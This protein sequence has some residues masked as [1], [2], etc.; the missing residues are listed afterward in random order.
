MFHL[1]LATDLKNNGF[2]I[3]P[4]DLCVAKN[5]LRGGVITVVRHVKNLKVPHKD[6]FEVTKFPQYLLTIYGYKL[7]VYRGNI[8]DYIGIY[9]YYS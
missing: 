1:K 5:W 3:N 2:S 8:N 4:H 9:L 7:K 6:P